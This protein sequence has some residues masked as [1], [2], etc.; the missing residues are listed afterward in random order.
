MIDTACAAPVPRRTRYVLQTAASAAFFGADIEAIL[1]DCHRGPHYQFVFS[2]RYGADDISE[3]SITT[4]ARRPDRL[5]GAKC[6]RPS[7]IPSPIQDGRYLISAQAE[8]IS[9][10]NDTIFCLTH[11]SL[12]CSRV[13]TEFKEANSI[14]SPRS[15]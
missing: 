15:Q 12:S 9:K 7:P 8:H 2:Q 4:S 6:T 14:K 5:F 13:M 3:Q 10:S 11:F 1:E